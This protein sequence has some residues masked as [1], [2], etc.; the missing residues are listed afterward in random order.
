MVNY[1]TSKRLSRLSYQIPLAVLYIVPVVL[2]I[3]LLFLPDTPRYYV[4]KDRSDKARKAIARLRGIKD[5]SILD[6]NVAEIELGWE[7]EKNL[8]NG[9]RLMD[10]F[11]G[12]DLR[13][14]LISFGASV[15]QTATG[16]V[17][18]SAF[19][20]YFFIQA[21]VTNAFMWVMVRALRFNFT[22]DLRRLL[23]TAN[24]SQVSLV[25]T[26]TANILSFPAMRFLPRRTLLMS[27]GLGASATMFT[28]AAVYDGLGVLSVVAAKAL[29]GVSIV[30]TWYVFNP[31]RCPLF[32][33]LQL[34]VGKIK[35]LWTRS[36]PSP[37]GSCNRSALSTTTLAYFGFRTGAELRLRLA[38]FLLHAILH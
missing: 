11:R 8:H 21:R 35:V 10:M 38:V 12:P 33:R 19:S 32:M 5:S 4:T 16:V 6:A 24:E 7:E 1:Y 20:V 3:A 25:I 22:R 30:Y 15:G 13:R 31:F 27:C 17:F 18:M 14:T 23:I 28:M 34:M 2:S 29:V 36:R 9:V 26:L 37:L